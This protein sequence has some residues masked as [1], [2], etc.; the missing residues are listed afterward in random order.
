[1]ERCM[2]KLLFLS[3]MLVCGSIVKPIEDVE[4]NRELKGFV[5]DVESSLEHIEAILDENANGISLADLQY[6]I[7]SLEAISNSSSQLYLK[8]L[9]IADGNGIV[10]N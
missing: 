9:E 5:E 3:A 8:A 2:K 4:V 6:L 10:L 1:M 7:T